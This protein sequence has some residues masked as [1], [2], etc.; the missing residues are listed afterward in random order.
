MSW[1]ND[2]FAAEMPSLLRE[3]GSEAVTL[4]RPHTLED[5]QEP[6]IVASLLS[7]GSFGA[8]SAAIALHLTGNA[9]LAGTL[10]KGL[11]LTIGATPYTAQ[12]DAIAASNQVV[13]AIS[14][15]LAAP[16]ADGATVNL[17]AY[18]E[19]P[20]TVDQGGGLR[21]DLTVKELPLELVGVVSSR[22][23]LARAGAPG[24]PRQGDLV[25]LADGT[26]LRLER[27]E[28]DW[29]GGWDLLLGVP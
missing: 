12:A 23:S 24:A 25:V 21:Q 16:L 15:V 5:R 11:V 8:G 2:T 22:L 26:T 3:L 7:N 13:V 18:L 20:F 14:P 6:R 10:P 9:G 1:I 4:R 17:A 29:E 19:L 27:I 28:R